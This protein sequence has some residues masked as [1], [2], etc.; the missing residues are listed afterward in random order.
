MIQLFVWTFADGE[1]P[2]DTANYTFT[3]DGVVKIMK[4]LLYL[5]TIHAI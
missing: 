5:M 4:K 1:A 2:T 3:P